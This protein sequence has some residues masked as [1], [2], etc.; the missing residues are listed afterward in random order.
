MN[1]PIPIDLDMHYLCFLSALRT[2]NNNSKSS[3]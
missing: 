3:S 1:M 2:H